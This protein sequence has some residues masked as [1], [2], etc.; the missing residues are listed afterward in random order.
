MRKILMVVAL[1]FCMG[2]GT[3][4]SFPSKGVATAIKNPIPEAAFTG[5]T[6]PVLRVKSYDWIGAAG[7]VYGH[8]SAFIIEHKE[9]LYIV[10]AFHVIEGA[11]VVEFSTHDNKPVA[12]EVDNLILMRHMDAALMKI[13]KISAKI[14]PLKLGKYALGGEV[15]AIGFPMN[16]EYKENK[17]HN[18]STQ[19]HTTANLISGMS[20]GPVLDGEGNVVGI[21]SATV[22]GDP[23]VKG[24]F[25]RLEDVF[26][27]IDAEKIDK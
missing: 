18:Y 19:S 17:G 27:R 8:G 23:E 4:G 16:G 5:E 9:S 26:C 24:I 25:S 11:T 15:T 3:V 22:L 7:A 14:N 2:C 20:G 21:V 1:L 6:K 13:K 10:T 12:I